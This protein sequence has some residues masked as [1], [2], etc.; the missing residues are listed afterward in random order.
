MTFSLMIGLS[1][2]ASGFLIVYCANTWNLPDSQAGAYII[3]MQIG[4]SLA[5]LFFGFLSDRKGHKVSL[6]IITLVIVASFLLAFLAPNPLWFY[7]IFFL[8]GRRSGRIDDLRYIH[9]A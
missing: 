8:R 3:A 9:C 5:N 4:Q 1:Q 2:M 6:E 7:P